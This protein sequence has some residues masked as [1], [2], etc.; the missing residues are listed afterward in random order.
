M[1]PG[2]K[3]PYRIKRQSMNL[4]LRTPDDD[5]KAINMNDHWTCSGDTD[6]DKRQEGWF[7]T[8]DKKLISAN[9]GRAACGE[10]K[11]GGNIYTCAASVGSKWI[12]NS[13]KQLQIEG[14]TKCLNF[15]ARGGDARDLFLNNCTESNGTKA[16]GSIIDV[17][18]ISDE[19]RYG[20]AQ[21]KRIDQHGWAYNSV[22]Q[23]IPPSS[24]DAKFACCKKSNSDAT[25]TECGYNYCLNS[26]TCNSFYDTDWCLDHPTSAECKDRP[27][28]TNLRKAQWCKQDYNRLVNDPECKRVCD[29]QEAGVRVECEKAAEQACTDHPEWTQ[30]ACFTKLKNLNDP[31]Y[32]DFVEGLSPSRI[33]SLGPSECWLKGCALPMTANSRFSDLFRHY[34]GNDGGLGCATCI[35]T[36]A[37]TNVKAGLGLTIDQTCNNYTGTAPAAGAPSP[38]PSGSPSP[39]P[40]PSPS[41]KPSPSPSPSAISSTAAT[42]GGIG[43]S[44]SLCMCCVCII[45]L[46]I[47]SMS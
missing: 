46:L 31:D 10:D 6:N 8:T 19:N 36:M 13:D 15:D 40:S 11:A 37:N 42:G 47:L 34:K 17:S 25:S 9:D 4:C 32:K 12:Y 5:G 29:T 3:E 27:S 26:Q 1:N 39:K 16:Q 2:N 21:C 24:R 43:L 44:F 18:A 20:I 23:D 35:Q 30:C 28:V 41:P 14:T 38:S 33:A 45:L 22:S 7:Y